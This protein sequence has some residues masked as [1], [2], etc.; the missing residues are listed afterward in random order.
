[1]CHHLYSHYKVDLYLMFR[2]SGRDRLAKV[3]A[4]C[5]KRLVLV[6]VPVQAF[7]IIWQWGFRADVRSKCEPMSTMRPKPKLPHLDGP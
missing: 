1:M 4:N 3:V 5:S 6:I 7:C 2:I